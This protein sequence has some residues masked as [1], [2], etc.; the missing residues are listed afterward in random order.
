MRDT[1][2]D[3]HTPNVSSS[4][5]AS[6]QSES[7]KTDKAGKPS[8]S[9]LLL[10]ALVLLGIAAYINVQRVRSNALPP[11]IPLPQTEVASKRLAAPSEGTGA[12]RF[13]S[14]TPDQT[15]VDFTHPVIPDHPQAYLYFSS[16][17]SGGTAVGDVNGDSRPDLFVA[18]GPLKNRLY[19]QTEEAFRF[20]DVSETAGIGGGDAWACGATMVDINADG[21]LD[22]YVAN[23]DSPNSLFVNLGNGKFKDMAWKY[24]L[25]L[26]NACL[27]ATFADYDRDGHLDMYL[28]NYRYENPGGMPHVA[29]IVEAAGGKRIKPEMEKYYEITNDSIGYG[30]V[31]RSDGLLRNQGDGTFRDVSAEAGIHGTAHGQSATWWDFND[32]GFPDLHVGND[33]N[34]ADSLYRNNGDGTFTDVVRDMVPHTTWFSMGADAGDLNGD[35]LPDLLTSDMSSTTHFK[36]KTTMGSMGNNIEFLSSAIPRQY[37]RNALLLNSG[38][39]RF[40]EAAYLANLDSTD[41]TWSVKLVDFDCDGLLDVFFTNGS[42][43]SFSDSDRVRTLSQRKGKTEWDLYKDTEPMRE[44]NLAFRNLGELNFESVGEAWGLNHVGVSMSSAHADFDGDGDLDLVVANIDEPLTIYRN[45]TTENNR[46]S[47]RLHGSGGNRFGIG[48]KV[49]VDTG[50]LQQTR[51]IQPSRG[52]LASN[53]PILHFGLGNQTT[54]TVT[55]RWP[56]GGYQTVEG[57]A[58]GQRYDITES[59]QLTPSKSPETTTLFQTKS[60]PQELKHQEQSFDDYKLQPL[61]PHRMSQLGP[62]IASADIDGDGAWDYFVGGA[63]GQPGRLALSENGSL[64]AV[65]QPALVTDQAA[66]DMGAIWLNVDGDGDEDLV[67]ASGSNEHDP[68]DDAYRLRL[69]LNDD[70]QLQRDTDRIPNIRVSGGPLAAADFDQDGDVDLFVGGRQV[71]GKYPLPAQSYLLINESGRLVD[72]TTE[73]VVGSSEF[74][75]VTGALWSDVDNDDDVDLMLTTEWGTIQLWRNQDGKL[76]DDT[77]AAGLSAYRGW[78][79]GITGGDLDNDGDVDYVVTNLG[80]NTKYHASDEH[81]FRMFYGDFDGTGERRLVEAEYEEDTLF[82]I[83]GKSCSTH[84]IP[85]LANKFTT[86]KAFAAASLED[87]YTTKCLEDAYECSANMLESV[88]LQN[89]GSGRFAVKALPREAQIAPAFGCVISNVT[90]DVFPDV[91]IAQNFFSPQPE[92]GNMD[93]GL[94]CLLRGSE[95]LQLTPV[96]A[97]KSGI[98]IPQDAKA[99]VITELN[100]DNTADLIV[101]TNDDAL[102]I[103]ESNAG[104]TADGQAGRST[105]ALFETV[106]VVFSAKSSSAVAGAKVRFTVENEPTQMV[107]ITSGSGYLSQSPPIFFF[108]RRKGKTAKIVVK[109]LDG[110]KVERIVGPNNPTVTLD[111]P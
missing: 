40:R 14:L 49:T 97:K 22:I 81:P 59:A 13:T 6:S 37:M 60:G 3:A 64:Q 103:V 12:T 33:F 57:L 23:Y 7:T 56:S 11:P 102:R 68:E 34:D 100:G 1:T 27:E 101:T 87:I 9:W 89:D 10:A 55:I 73:H 50:D 107:E 76:R 51:E 24:G 91:F 58:A 25:N 17:A 42:V 38:T 20:E 31:G 92:T 69:Y 21:R 53:E 95:S 105:D 35:G 28:V 39:N 52:F 16:M 29:P 88:I 63:A 62:S 99:C 65:T 5:P 74:G 8:Q 61:L 86:Y 46:L 94:G 70:G 32:D 80:L 15:G 67:V 75:M 108:K 19:V 2:Q 54:A 104:A 110:T 78:W 96:A 111:K 90:D 44:A 98:V 26:T 109:S 79:T 77:A 85:S 47:I 30:T 18:S 71:P 83:R 36:Q 106:Q 48:S 93:G 4:A 41:W 72:R 43:R 45:D 82:P 84:A 66:E